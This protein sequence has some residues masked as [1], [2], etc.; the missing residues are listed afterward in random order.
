MEEVS[1]SP[2]RAVYVVLISWEG[3][4]SGIFGQFSY[5]LNCKF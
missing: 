1:P 3:N 4:F 2:D 5:S